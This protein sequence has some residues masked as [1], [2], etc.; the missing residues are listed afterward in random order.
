MEPPV[1]PDVERENHMMQ[2]HN[3]GR[4]LLKRESMERAE[5]YV[6]QLQGYNLHATM[7]RDEP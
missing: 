7:E 2:V 1:R 6:H 4:S 3:Q 5:F